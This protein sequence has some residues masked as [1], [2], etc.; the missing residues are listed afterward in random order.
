MDSKIENGEYWRLGRSY[1]GLP[2]EK[3]IVEAMHFFAPNRDLDHNNFD[4]IEE[5]FSDWG[6]GS[7]IKDH[8][9]GFSMEAKN[10]TLDAP[11]GKK[12]YLGISWGDREIVPRFKDDELDYQY[13]A[14]YDIRTLTKNHRDYLETEYGITA[15]GVIRPDIKEDINWEWA[16]ERYF[17]RWMIFNYYVIPQYRKI[18]DN[19]NRSNLLKF[20]MY[21]K[22]NLYTMEPSKWNKKRLERKHYRGDYDAIREWWKTKDD[23][24]NVELE[25]ISVEVDSVLSNVCSVEKNT[26]LSI[27]DWLTHRFNDKK[28]QDNPTHIC[29]FSTYIYTHIR[30]NNYIFAKIGLLY[31]YHIN[32]INH[33]IPIRFNS[34]I[35]PYIKDILSKFDNIPIRLPIK[36]YMDVDNLGDL[37]P[38][39]LKT[40]HPTR[41]A[42]WR[43][44]Q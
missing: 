23:P 31:G 16:K 5:Y 1:Q 36:P 39:I 18:K 32:S 9:V 6:K 30:R 40:Y 11:N 22:D 20:R 17:Y 29:E 13:V 41:P 4:D 43:F 37:Q 7:D 25:S 27:D 33:T 34:Y 44:Q 15:V 42:R 28:E 3:K 21:A 35:L 26:S 8:A 14:L 19:I 38:A 10:I 12:Q 2:H 24:V